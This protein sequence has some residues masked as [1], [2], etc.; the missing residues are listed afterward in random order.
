MWGANV[1]SLS[2]SLFF[3]GV[4]LIAVGACATP[5]SGGP[6]PTSRDR[7][8]VRYTALPAMIDRETGRLIAVVVMEN[9]RELPSAVTLATKNCHLQ[10]ELYASVGREPPPV[11]S[12]R[13]LGISCV[14]AVEIVPLDALG[15]RAT[16]R[17]AVPITLV[18]GDSLPAGTYAVT[19]MVR[20]GD[21]ARFG[22][23]AGSVTLP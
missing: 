15:S 6:M 12:Q 11:W 21:G 5:Q 4:V 1:I 19:S 23:A 22:L 9:M 3:G 14:Q 17:A 10:L 2:R 20:I 18:M 8:N 13:N 16:L 7:G